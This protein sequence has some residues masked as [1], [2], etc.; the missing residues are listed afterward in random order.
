MMERNP[1]LDAQHTHGSEED[2]FERSLRPGQLEDFTG[3]DHL[4][5]N[6]K[7]EG[8]AT[9]NDLKNFDR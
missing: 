9:A 3:Q 7:E 8:D 4:K 5:E 2:A 1:N 6:L